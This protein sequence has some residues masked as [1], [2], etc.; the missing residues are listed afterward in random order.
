MKDKKVIDLREILLDAVGDC[1]KY[2]KITF[3]GESYYGEDAIRKGFDLVALIEHF[4]REFS[5]KKE[6]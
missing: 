4:D 3:D 2:R 6:K 1:F 5:Y